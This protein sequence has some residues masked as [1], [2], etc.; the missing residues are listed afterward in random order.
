MLEFPETFNLA[1]H[2]LDARIQEGNGQRIA[3]R[4]GEE[5]YTYEDIYNTVNR[6]GN[7]LLSLGVAMEQRVVIIMPDQPEFIISWLAAVKIGAVVN[8]LNP[9]YPAADYPPYLKHVRPTVL[10]VHDSVADKLNGIIPEFKSIRHVIV[11][12]EKRDGYLSFEDVIRDASA[13]LTP[14]GTA[15]SSDDGVPTVVNQ[16]W[17]TARVAP[18]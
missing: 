1:A 16:S 17:W 4:Y 12:G 5:S 7:A 9:L 3:I 2:H 11:V 18:T 15:P 14:G 10:I 13:S 6:L 8:T